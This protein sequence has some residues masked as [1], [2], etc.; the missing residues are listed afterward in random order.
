LLAGDRNFELCELKVGHITDDFALPPYNLPY[1]LVDIQNRKGWLKKAN[2]G[3]T[4]EDDGP[5]ESA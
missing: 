1:F 3:W 5:L 2:G 4:R